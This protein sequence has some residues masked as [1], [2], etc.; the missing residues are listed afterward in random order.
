MMRRG[1]EVDHAIAAIAAA[2]NRVVSC[3]ELAAVGI[4]RRAVAHRV[5]IGR[6]YRHYTGVYLI[7]PPREASRITLLTAAVAACGDSAVL[8]H[9]S[10]AELWG[11]VPPHPGDIEVTIV[12]RNAGERPGI[13]RHRVPALDP[14]DIGTKRGIRVT[15]PARTVFDSA[16]CLY[17]DDFEELVAEA[18]A[19]GLVDERKLQS[20]IA[21]YPTRRGASRLSALLGQAG[22]PRRTR[23]KK[24]GRLLSLVRQAKLPVPITNVLLHGHQVDALWPHHKLVVEVDGWDFHRDRTAFENDRARDAILVANGY[25]V[26]RFTARQLDDQPLTV[27]ARLSAALALTPP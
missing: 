22:G 1:A 21:R 3:R 13:R 8:S 25:R 17:G 19:K 14:R 23:S 11:W 5:S 24:E 20:V 7:E 26:L 27:I 10:A 18:I 12:A 9:R 15:S 6:L 16:S 4:G 2:N